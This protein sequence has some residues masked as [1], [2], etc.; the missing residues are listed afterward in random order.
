MT[1]ISGD[2]GEGIVSN[3]HTEDPASSVPLQTVVCKVDCPSYGQNQR[4]G[5]AQI[6]ASDHLDDPSS[7]IPLQIII[8]K[9]DSPPDDQPFFG[10]MR[11]KFAPGL[12]LVWRIL[13][14]KFQLKRTNGSGV[15][16]K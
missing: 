16:A 2:G 3:H 10:Q 13:N 15:R 6:V 9:E 11:L 7:S 8:C 1:K 14:T 4:D 12:P 5:G